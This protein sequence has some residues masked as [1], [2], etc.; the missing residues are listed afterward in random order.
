VEHV[1]LRQQYFRQ[2]TLHKQ[3]PHGT[4]FRDLQHQREDDFYR[5]ALQAFEWDWL[6][7]KTGQA[8]GLE[9]SLRVIQVGLTLFITDHR[10]PTGSQHLHH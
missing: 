1:S 9:V 8:R 5:P 4:I 7:K 2:V 6:R 10:H 3:Y